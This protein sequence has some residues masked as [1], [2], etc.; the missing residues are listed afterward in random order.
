MCR[1]VV[2]GAGGEHGTKQTGADQHG[3]TEGHYTLTYEDIFRARDGVV[4][5]A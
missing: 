2:P 5:R 3:R 1:G 4:A